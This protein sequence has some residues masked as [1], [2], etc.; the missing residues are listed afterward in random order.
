MLAKEMPQRISFRT[1]APFVNGFRNQLLASACFPLINTVAP[2]IRAFAK[3]STL[4]YQAVGQ[5]FV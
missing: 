3:G 1:I 2:G 4:T 5:Q